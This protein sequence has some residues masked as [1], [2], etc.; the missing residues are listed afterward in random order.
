MKASS[1][2]V[3][4]QSMLAVV[5]ALAALGGQASLSA[6][7]SWIEQHTT[8]ASRIPAKSKLDPKDH[9]EREVRFARHELANGGALISVDGRWKLLHPEDAVLLSAD[10]MRSMRR[11]NL[12]DRRLGHEESAPDGKPLLS[13]GDRARSSLQSGPTTG[14]IPS[15]WEGL[16]TRTHGPAY[17]YA[18]RF[19]ESDVWK[20]GHAS[21]L[22]KR[23]REVNQHIPIELLGRQW[24]SVFDRFWPSSL[25]AYEMEQEVLRALTVDRTL[26]ERVCCD[27]EKIQHAWKV[28]ITET[29]ARSR[30]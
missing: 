15:S 19:E 14:P 25:L 30:T 12:R 10:D 20:I 11:Q 9:F 8:L 18:L 3:R 7:Y 13:V 1:D 29:K 2:D 17:T 22:E 23:L 4:T 28:G 24:I 5:E 6:T 26:Y 16:V 21:N 27:R